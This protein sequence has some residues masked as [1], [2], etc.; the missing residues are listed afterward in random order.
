MPTTTLSR[1]T[2]PRT[3][4]TI[5]AVPPSRET[6]PHV[7]QSMKRLVEALKRFRK[8]RSTP[9]P[10]YDGDSMKGDTLC[11]SKRS[12]ESKVKPTADPPTRPMKSVTF[13]LPESGPLTPEPESPPRNA[14][15]PENDEAD[16]RL[17]HT[18]QLRKTSDNVYI[19]SPPRQRSRVRMRRELRKSLRSRIIGTT[20]S[21][22]ERGDYALGP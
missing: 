17:T 13:N 12:G 6:G 18:A 4:P 7:V 1:E 16:A 19:L 2:S 20:G 3:N 5:I 22:V 8:P 14:K 10:H 9:Y 15:N 21:L 11:D